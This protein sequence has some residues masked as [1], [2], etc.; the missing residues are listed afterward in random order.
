[1]F[2]FVQIYMKMSGILYRKEFKRYIREKYCMYVRSK[3]PKMYVLYGE[4]KDYRRIEK[5][6]DKSHE[7]FTC[8]E[9]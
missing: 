5:K 7:R 3:K 2:S 8:I 1:M 6:L 4:E 9:D